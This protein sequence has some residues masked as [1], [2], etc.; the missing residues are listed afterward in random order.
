MKTHEKFMKIC[1]DL[2]QLGLKKTETNPLVGCV[3]VHNGIIISE[4]Y[5][6]KFGDSHA[7]VNAIK[8][9]KNTR[10]S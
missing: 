5:H 2:A 6:K 7:E 4:G 3:I 10:T 1:L 8:K 9:V